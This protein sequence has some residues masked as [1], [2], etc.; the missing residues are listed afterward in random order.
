[1]AVKDFTFKVDFKTKNSLCMAHV[2]QLDKAIFNIYLT[3]QGQAMDLTGQQVRLFVRKPDKKLVVQ[4][5]D[6]TIT[7]A[8]GGAIKVDVHNSIFEAVGVGVCEIDVWGTDGEVAS[9]NFLINIDE[10]IGSNEA[11]E[12]HVDVNL[13]RQLTEYIDEANAEITKY[14]TLMEGFVSAGVSLQGLVDIKKYIDDNLAGLK[15]Q[16]DRADTLIPK[17]QKATADAEAKRVEVVNVTANAETKRS[18]VVAVTNTAESKKVEVVNATNTA[19]A[20]KIALESATASGDTKKKELETATA[21][22]EAKRKEV[23]SVT[24]TADASKTAL[25]SA[26]ASA[27][28]KKT[29]VVNA[30]ASAEAKRVEVVNATNTANTTKTALV[31]ATNTAN[32]SKAGLDASIASGNTLKAGLDASIKTA[33]TT[34]SGLD[35][36]IASAG[37]KK[38]DLDTSIANGETKRLQVV[39]VTN[40]AEAKRKELQDMINQVGSASFVTQGAMDTALKAKLGINDTAVNSSKLAGNTLYSSGGQGIPFV[41]TDGV[42]EVGNYIDFHQAGSTADYDGRLSLAGNGNLTYSKSFEA[43]SITAYDG[44]FQANGNGKFLK[45]GTGGADCY[46]TN[47]KT[48]AYLQLK[49]DGNLDYSGKILLSAYLPP[50][51]NANITVNSK[52]DGNNRGDGNTHI[53]YNTGHGYSHFFR[54]AGE[55]NIDTLNGAFVKTNPVLCGVNTGEYNGISVNGDDNGWIRT[56]KS[57]LLPHIADWNGGCSIG[58]GSWAFREGNFRYI[59][60]PTGQNLDVDGRNGTIYMNVHSASGCALIVDRSWGGTSGTEACV[61]N[62]MG[63][64]W[65][66][67]GNTGSAFYRIYGNGG[68]VSERARK[69]DIHKFDNYYLYDQLKMLNTYGYRTI[70]DT[71]DSDGNVT[72]QLKRSDMQLGCMID[73]LPTEVVLYD[74]EGGAGKAVDIYAYCTMILGTAKVLQ[75]KVETLE[76]QYSALDERLKKLEGVK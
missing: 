46:L 69:Y 64:G 73:E 53:N 30:T 7:D 36:S 62:S 35:S 1:M 43:Q 31:N 28:S 61:H 66:F 17:V 5:T 38:S 50:A 24:A 48:S 76:A 41:S 12:S 56:P 32:T 8:K 47:S 67:L 29:E 51:N 49:D 70:S 18:E 27:D 22:A 57:G 33:G 11:V 71:V 75:E 14:K 65:G 37:T 60:S 4:D 72:S 2:K 25:Q 16:G 55:F 3:D 74:N 23:V 40:T 19:N 42:M 54:G 59:C 68:N 10:Q 6:I 26:T 21:N 13:F 58:S 20:S 44:S 15:A 63:N 45:M 9:G 52:A 34:K 39:A